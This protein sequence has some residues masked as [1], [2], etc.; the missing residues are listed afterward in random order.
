MAFH[1]VH[2]DAVQR[3]P[4]RFVEGIDA[5]AW[6]EGDAPYAR[7]PIDVNRFDFLRYYGEITLIKEKDSSLNYRYGRQFLKYGGQRLLSP[8]AWSNTFRNFEG[9]KL[10]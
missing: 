7:V 8:L 5:S 6:Q 1:S 3:T 2:E 4:R 10:V 9:H